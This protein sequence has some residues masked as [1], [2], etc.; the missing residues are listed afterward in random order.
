MAVFG[1]VVVLSPKKEEEKDRN[2]GTKQMLD[3]SNIVLR[4]IGSDKP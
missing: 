4:R 3:A 1:A 2:T